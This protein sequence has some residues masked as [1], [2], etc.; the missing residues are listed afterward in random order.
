ML[1]DNLLA[2]LL[3]LHEANQTLERSFVETN[4]DGLKRLFDQGLSCYS[5]T[6]MTAG[7]IRFRQVYEGVLT[8]KGLQLARQA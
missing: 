4:A 1:T 3:K 5:I 7:N 6:L 8:P 2:E